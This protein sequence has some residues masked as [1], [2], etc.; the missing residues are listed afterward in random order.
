MILIPRGGDRPR[1]RFYLC[2]ALLER[3]GLTVA[4]GF[5]LPPI[6]PGTVSSC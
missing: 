2:L 3:G 5:I 6:A 1:V 4:I